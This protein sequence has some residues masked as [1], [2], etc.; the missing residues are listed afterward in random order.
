MKN[1]IENEL[2]TEKDKEAHKDKIEL[3]KPTIFIS[4]NTKDQ[5]YAEKVCDFLEKIGVEYNDITCTSVKSIPQGHD[6]KE[7]L[8]KKLTKSS[9]VV[10]PLISEDYYGSVVSV[11]ELGASWVLGSDIIPILIPPMEF[12]KLD[13]IINRTQGFKINDEN[14]WTEFASRI[15]NLFG[16]K[17][18][19]STDLKR[20]TKSIVTDMDNLKKLKEK[21]PQ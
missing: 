11:M 4:H 15:V 1:E 8:E 21:I 10:L 14:E 9:V 17:E 13:S 6:F 16:L 18:L 20:Y 19:S 5:D 3:V 7:Y 2:K 12:D